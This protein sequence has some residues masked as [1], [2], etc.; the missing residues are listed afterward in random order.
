MI[1]NTSGGESGGESGA[2]PSP[3]GMLRPG[4]R[5]HEHPKVAAVLRQWRR[6]QDVRPDVAQVDPG[7]G[8][9][10]FGLI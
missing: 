10:L 4:L 1:T 3:R 5:K 9:E 7:V 2:S 8:E 6:P